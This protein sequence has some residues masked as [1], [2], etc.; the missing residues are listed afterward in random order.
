[1]ELNTK[2]AL[3]DTT[4]DCPS[5]LREALEAWK[6]NK[7]S[8]KDLVEASFYAMLDFLSAY[9][10]RA[11]PTPPKEVR[12]YRELSQ[13]VKNRME[14]KNK[15]RTYEDNKAFYESEAQIKDM[16]CANRNR[17]EEL[18]DWAKGKA[19]SVDILSS[20]QSLI[21]AWEN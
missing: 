21:W 8:S 1:M 17:L 20:I 3:P 2:E 6:I 16:N 7:L 19:L 15:T 10:Y 18:L 12:E 4:N 11:L 14:D 9:R 5:S 13:T